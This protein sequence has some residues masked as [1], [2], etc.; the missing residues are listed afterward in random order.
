MEVSLLMTRRLKTLVAPL[1]VCVA[2]LGWCAQAQAAKG[3]EVALSDDTVFLYGLKNPFTGLDRAQQLHTTW[4][5]VNV[6]WTRVLGESQS[7]AR[8]QPK[9]LS[10]NFVPYDDIVNRAADRGIGVEFTLT[11][12]A[13][14]WATGNKKVGHY[15]VKG[16]K[17]GAFARAFAARYRGRTVRYSIWNEPNIS[18]WLLP[19][20]R[21]PKIYRS[22]YSSAYS[23]IK[24]V[25]PGAKVFIGETAPYFMPRRTTAPLKFLRGV[26][27]VNG[28][29]RHPRCKGLKTD[30]Y[31][32]HPY[33]F[34]HKPTYKYPGK[35]NVTVAT[36]GRLNSALS[37]LKRS[38]ALK[39]PRGGVP[40]L[41]LTEYG[42]FAAY[43]YKLSRSKQAAY[44]KKGFQIAR[45]TPRV[46][47]MLQYLLVPPPR[48]LR[49][50]STQI[51]SGSFKPYKAFNTLRA[52]TDSQAKSHGIATVAKR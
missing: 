19:L 50:F 38:G 22:M 13:P 12:Q 36:L 17:F 25:D 5:R 31:A 52:W 40:N 41:Y 37:K 9:N 10:Y 30:G 26:T 7:Q 34:R 33:D 45:K 4:I 29:Y 23:N 18:A 49:F 43:K 35:D 24:A 44:L 8:T 20:K 1:V 42:Y 46:K 48:A 47:Q 11:G 51:M 2:A 32:H 21:A 14:R 6:Q 28:S 15:K 16:S 3:M 27:C 39:T